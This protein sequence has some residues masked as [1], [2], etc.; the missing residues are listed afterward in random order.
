MQLSILIPCLNEEA[1]IGPCLDSILTQ[2]GYSSEWEILVLD[3]MST[4][5]TRRIVS[6]YSKVHPNIR[7]IDNPR[8]IQ[9]SAMNIGIRESRGEIIIRMDAHTVYEYNYV[10]AC[11]EVLQETGAQNVGGPVQATW[12]TP[13]QEANAAV[14]ASRFAVGGA[15]FHFETARGEVDSVPFGCW[16][17]QTLLELGGYDETFVRNE[18]DELNLRLIRTG[19]RIWLDPRIRSLYSPRAS[20]KGVWWQYYQYGF[21][22]VPVILKHRIPASPRHLV[23][24]TFLLFLLSAPLWFV[25]PL[26]I[27]LWTI[28][29]GFYALLTTLFALVSGKNHGPTVRLRMMLLFPFYHLSYG[30]GFLLGVVHFIVFRRQAGQTGRAANELTR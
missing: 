21:W 27:R 13:F 19:G 20:W 23:P 17:R 12:S 22:K 18:D 14:Y 8:R 1:F 28:V 15:S 25:I 5:G 16:R 29:T 24:A 26:G 3:G 11:T 30:A 7:L 6:E 9:A 4:D 2:R 10:I